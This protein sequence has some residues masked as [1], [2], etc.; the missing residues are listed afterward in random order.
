MS[1]VK[2][3]MSNQAPMTNV[4]TKAGTRPDRVFFKEAFEDLGI[5]S[6]VLTFELWHLSL[7]VIRSFQN[8]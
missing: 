6:G 8:V 2:T 1:N 4:Q 5:E 7:A 3:Q